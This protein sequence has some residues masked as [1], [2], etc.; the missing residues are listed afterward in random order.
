MTIIDENGIITFQ[1]TLFSSKEIDMT[2]LP[3]QSDFS[4]DYLLILAVKGKRFKCGLISL[5]K[6]QE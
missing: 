3:Q 6:G 1:E 5:V 4:E 2:Y